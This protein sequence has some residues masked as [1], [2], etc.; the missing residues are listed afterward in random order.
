M[1]GARSGR[2]AAWDKKG[3]AE[4]GRTLLLEP[5]GEVGRDARG[6]AGHDDAVIVIP[7]T[8]R[9]SLVKGLA[10]RLVVDARGFSQS[11]VIHRA[12]LDSQRRAAE[13]CASDSSQSTESSNCC[14]A[15][16]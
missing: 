1:G 7:R 11:L 3:V 12:N 8:G 14:K 6:G 10:H 4:A 5:G 9:S 16:W 13:L 15:L 2:G